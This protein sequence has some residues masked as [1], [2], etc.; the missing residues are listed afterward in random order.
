VTDARAEIETAREFAERFA[1]RNALGLSLAEARAEAERELAGG[2]PSY[3][4]YSFGLSTGTLGKPGV[5]LTN[6]RERDAWVGAMLGKFLP[7]RMLL[8]ADIALVLKH[9]NRL[10]SNVSKARGGLRLH[11]FSAAVPVAE[12]IDRLRALAPAVLIGP[13]SVLGQLGPLKPSLVLAVAEPMFPQ[14]RAA[15]RD[16]FGVEPL[17]IYQAKEGFLAAGCACGALHLNEDL[18]VF[19]RVPL[20]R[21]RFIPVITDVTRTSQTYRRF[22]MDDVL[23]ES[24]NRCQRPFTRIECVEGR[25]NDVLLF[26]ERIVFPLEVNAVMTAEGRD[27]RVTQSGP[28][29]VRVAVEGGVSKQ[30][31]EA[32]RELVPEAAVTVEPYERTPC[33]QKRRR[34][35][36]LFDPHNEWLTRFTASRKI[37][38]G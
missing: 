19:E 34:V 1:E 9:N 4:G 8:G 35:R 26:G 20:E 32:L 15:L 38:S 13:V 22:R 27:Y 29:D 23:M 10:Y 24:N 12:W 2:G 31:L 7:L 18:I 14:D 5:F 37:R 21:G 30:V 3:P 36:R 17:G 25:A 16:Q 6:Q 28:Q 33:G 11:Y